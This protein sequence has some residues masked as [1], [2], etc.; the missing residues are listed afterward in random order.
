MI[1]ESSE[2][3][4]QTNESAS[5]ASSDDM[6]AALADMK[7]SS[8]SMSAAIDAAGITPDTLAGSHDRAT[9]GEHDAVRPATEE[10]S[11]G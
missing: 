11:Q 9:A 1:E 8:P 2:Q 4:S 3:P 5:T 6:A 7:G 10:G